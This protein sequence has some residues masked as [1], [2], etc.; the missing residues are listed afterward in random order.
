MLEPEEI[1]RARLER[2]QE[3]QWQRELQRQRMASL[4]ADAAALDSPI[5]V[6]VGNVGETP[7]TVDPA[8]SGGAVAT[9]RPMSALDLYAAAMQQAIRFGRNNQ[10]HLAPGADQTYAFAFSDW[11][12]DAQGFPQSGG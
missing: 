10:W 1:W 5:A 3:E 8:M 6:D 11:H 12:F 9:N 4:Q 2:E 7:P